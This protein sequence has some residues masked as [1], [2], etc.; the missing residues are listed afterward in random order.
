MDGGREH[1]ALFVTVPAGDTDTV[2]AQSW[3]FQHFTPLCFISQIQLFLASPGRGFWDDGFGVSGHSIFVD[4][5]RIQASLDTRL[6]Q[7]VSHKT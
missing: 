5:L 6:N 2:R 1:G 3:V 4:P 7:I